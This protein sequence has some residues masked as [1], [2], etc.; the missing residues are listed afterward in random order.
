MIDKFDI[1]FKDIHPSTGTTLKDNPELFR[2]EEEE[3]KKLWEEYRKQRAK[4]IKRMWFR[5]LLRW[6]TGRKPLLID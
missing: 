2:Q 6:L 4:A 3:I 1:L 5:N